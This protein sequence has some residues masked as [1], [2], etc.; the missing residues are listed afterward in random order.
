MRSFV[1][2]ITFALWRYHMRSL[3]LLRLTAI[4]QG[5]VEHAAVQ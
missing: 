4:E 5:N 2:S 1:S 3:R